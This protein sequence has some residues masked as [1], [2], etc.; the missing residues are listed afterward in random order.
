MVHLVR[1]NFFC[2]YFSPSDRIRVH[3][4][5]S[6][7]HDQ[8]STRYAHYVKNWLQNYQNFFLG[9]LKMSSTGNN[10]SRPAG[11]IFQ[12][13][14]L[15]GRQ[16][17]YIYLQLLPLQTDRYEFALSWRLVSLSTATQ[18]YSFSI[19]KLAFMING[20]QAT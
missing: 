13:Q 2:A 20:T 12:L 17:V 14:W 5:E 6:S 4:H 11:I 16:C 15:V 19:H 10:L 9:S 7:N 18:S 3:Q 8:H 1:L